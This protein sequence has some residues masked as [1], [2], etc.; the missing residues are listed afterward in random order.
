ML[1]NGLEIGNGY[2]SATT[3]QNSPVRSGNATAK[4][5]NENTKKKI[6]FLKK[7]EK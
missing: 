4:S 1:Q 3:R 2:D 5:L 7:V 6:F